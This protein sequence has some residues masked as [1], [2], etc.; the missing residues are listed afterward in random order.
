MKNKLIKKKSKYY[1]MDWFIKMTLVIS[2]IRNLNLRKYNFKIIKILIKFIPRL[3]LQKVHKI[4]LKS[5]HSTLIKKKEI[6]VQSEI[7]F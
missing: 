6:K 4:I 3:N 1:L 5:N 2:Q 7:I